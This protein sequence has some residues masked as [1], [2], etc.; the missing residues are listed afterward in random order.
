MLP[1]PLLRFLRILLPEGLDDGLMLFEG[2]FHSIRKASR[3]Q[4]EDTDM[5]VKTGDQLNEP[6]GVRERDNTLMKFEVLPGIALDVLLAERFLEALEAG[7]QPGQT[8]FRYPFRSQASRQ[9]FQVFADE[10]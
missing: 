4:A 9:S 2:R 1:H 3:G 6:P 8:G 7:F 10:E 5:I